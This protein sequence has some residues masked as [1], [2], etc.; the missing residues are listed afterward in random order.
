[1]NI[2]AAT[3]KNYVLTAADV[4]LT[5]QGKVHASSPYGSGDAASRVVDRVRLA[6]GVSR[7]KPFV[8]AEEG[9]L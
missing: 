9:D 5:V 7:V 2:A 4:G 8:D 1:M 3:T 6:P